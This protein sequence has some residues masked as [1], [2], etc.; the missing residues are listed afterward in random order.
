MIILNEAEISKA[1]D[2][3]LKL[4]NIHACM[5]ASRKGNNV[6]PGSENF[7]PGV[8]KVWNDIIQPTTGNV[9][10]MIDHFLP[11][12]LKKMDFQLKDY[13]VFFHMFPDEE[14]TLITVVPAQISDKGMLEIEMENTRRKIIEIMETQNK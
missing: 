11:V 5:V 9:F 10:R 14:N 13:E 6:M 7:K 2:N 1:L 3:L 8:N 12:G 4:D